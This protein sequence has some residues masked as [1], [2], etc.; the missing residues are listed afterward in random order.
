[1]EEQLS[2]RDED[3]PSEKPFASSMPTGHAGEEA[4]SVVL[5]ASLNLIP[6]LGGPMSSLF[7]GG[8]AM[9]DRRKQEKWLH[10]LALAVDELRENTTLQL[11]DIVQDE[12]FTTAVIRGLRIVRET[13]RSEKLRIV[14]NAV[15]NSGSWAANDAALQ[16]YF[17]RLL[18]RYEPE[19]IMLLRACDEP[20]KFIQD[21]GEKVGDGKLHSIFEN[22]IYKGNTQWESL[23]HIVLRD[24]GQDQLLRTGGMGLGFSLAEENTRLSSPIGHEFLTFCSIPYKENQIG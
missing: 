21:Y 2:K 18:E 14:T 11:E 17:M 1:M 19:H 5:N 8:L 22:I 7:T 15:C 10:S 9:T 24:L 3:E 20:T 6:V 4:A 13:D 23:A 12:A 16:T